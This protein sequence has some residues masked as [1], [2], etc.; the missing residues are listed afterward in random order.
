MNKTTPALALVLL[1]T[2]VPA[3]SSTAARQS[4]E[5]LITQEQAA[6]SAPDAWA[7]GPETDGEVAA[8]WAGIIHDETLLALMSEALA[9]NPSLRASA[10][11]VRRSEAF[12]RQ[13]RS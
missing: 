10:E 9:A 11:S 2:V 8:T 13:S 7:F 4:P 1:A 12:L 5:A 6:L 3:C